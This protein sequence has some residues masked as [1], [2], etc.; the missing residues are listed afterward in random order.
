MTLLFV[1]FCD[2]L[3][4]LEA[5]SNHDPTF[6][7]SEQRRKV[8]EAISAWFLTHR[9]KVQPQIILSALFPA[10]RTDRVYSIQCK[11]LSR[12]LGRFLSLG[13]AR[14]QELNKYLTPGHG[15]LGQCVERVQQQS[16]FHPP[17]QSKA[18][19]LQQ[20]EDSFD[21]L[22]SRSAFS[23]RDVRACSLDLDQNVLTLDSI[24]KLLQSREMKWMTRLLLKDFSTI[25]LGSYTDLIYSCIDP[26]LCLAMQMHDNIMEAVKA[27]PILRPAEYANARLPVGSNVLSPQIG[28]KIGPARWVKAKGGIDHALSLIGSHAMS[29]ERKYDGEYCQIHVDLERK[30]GVFQIFS[31]S[32]KDSTEDRKHVIP[33]LEDGLR[34]G[35]TNRKF[36]RKCIIEGELVVWSDRD[37]SILEFHKLRKHIA[38][39]GLYIG[40]KEDS[41]PHSWEHLML[42]LYDILLLDDDTVLHRPQRHRRWLLEQVVKPIRGR[43]ALADRTQVDFSKKADA[44]YELKKR[45]AEAFANRWEGLVLKPAAEAYFG[46]AKGPLGSRSP[47]IKLKK[48]CIAGFGD[49]ADFAVVG[50]GYD[51][52]RA[53][54]LGLQDIKWT[55]FF[56]G[57]LKNK[58][59]VCENKARPDFLVVDCVTNC[60]SQE[61]F[62]MLSQQGPFSARESNVSSPYTHIN[63][64]SI[65]MDPRLPAMTATFQ[66]PFVF[67]I[68][69]SG[70]ERGSN[71]RIYTLRFPRVLK[72][73]LDVDWR[74]CVDCHQLQ[75]MAGD[76][77]IPPQATLEEEMSAWTINLDST[78][79]YPRSVD[80]EEHSDSGHSE[81]EAQVHEHLSDGGRRAKSGKL[82]PL[83]RMDTSELYEGEVRTDHE[84]RAT[85][86]VFNAAD[87]PCQ[88]SSLIIPDTATG[89]NP[90][91]L[92]VNRKRSFLEISASP[93]P[94]FFAGW[95]TRTPEPLREIPNAAN[96]N[97]PDEIGQANGRREAGE[98]YLDLVRK[99]ATGI[100]ASSRRPKRREIRYIRSSPDQETTS[101]E[102]SSAASTQIRTLY[103]VASQPKTKRGQG[104]VKAA[105]LVTP[106]S[107]AEVKNVF[108]LPDAHDCIAFMDNTRTPSESLRR[109]YRTSRVGLKRILR[110][111]CQLFSPPVNSTLDFSDQ[112]IFLVDS[113]HITQATQGFLDITA[114]MLKVKKAITVWDWRILQWLVEDDENVLPEENAWEQLFLASM[115]LESEGGDGDPKDIIVKWHDVVTERVSDAKAQRLGRELEERLKKFA[116]KQ[117]RSAP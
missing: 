110:P 48:D 83:I 101:D 41:Q 27:L 3:E 105:G 86:I 54:Q 65:Y 14:F 25:A 75:S 12:Q 19:M 58:V 23:S 93:S 107:T 16:E 88:A 6:L 30:Y 31:K 68:A 92:S 79:K 106:P 77:R 47:W 5:I 66:T 20:V 46:P 97:P 8:T 91:A 117:K 55:H 33:A 36:A 82:P 26:R 51:A 72:V 50:A 61:D 13:H 9:P 108:S 70:F 22:A 39:S 29:L 4:A 103:A 63:L 87:A 40:T 112:V 78:T 104:H 96:Y 37:N 111:V 115:E 90:P 18:L 38:R 80:A 114:C 15:D 59:A 24:Y 95:P 81:V 73:R 52:K 102:C 49:S 10:R 2:L 28:V 42:I 116:R 43:I 1:H 71:R 100:E 44:V 98:C 84:A 57:C 89:I 32:G 56:L 69:G 85:S 21:Q 74:D 76:A 62:R 67:D 60:I 11:R 53:H 109:Y 94:S 99:H 7:P 35:D 113:R 64:E 17:P 34:I 45:L